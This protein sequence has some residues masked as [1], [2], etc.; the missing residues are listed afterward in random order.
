MGDSGSGR[1]RSLAPGT[2]TRPAEV[3]VGKVICRGEEGGRTGE[4]A[5]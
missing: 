3:G 1:H 2:K 5:G 4:G